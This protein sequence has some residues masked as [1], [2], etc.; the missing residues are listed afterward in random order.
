MA[1][2]HE[3]P[4]FED[5]WTHLYL[6]RGGLDKDKEGLVFRQGEGRTLIPIDQL[7]LVMLGPG[8]SITQQAAKALA[9]NNCL[10]CFVGEEGV[11]MYAFATGG[12]HSA[13]R[14]LRQ[15]EL[16]ASPAEREHVARRM[17]LKR[18]PSPVAT[19]VT[20]Q[21]LRGMEG[22]RVRKTYE[23]MALDH[24][25]KWE[26]RNYDQSSWHTADPLNR[27]LSSA[28]A[29][30]YSLCHAAILSA[31]YSPAIGFIHTGKVL[32]FVYD[33][34]DL[35][36]TEI[37]IPLAFK[38]AA[39]T[40][41][42]VERTARLACRD[43]FKKTKLIQRILPDIAEVLDARDDLGEGADELEGRAISLA[44]RAQGW[45]FP[46]KPDGQNTG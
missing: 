22:A 24:G 40:Q 30:L 38:A 27:A 32:S 31:G 15:A 16:Y 25:V 26:G 41:D 29:C 10:M 18:F 14:L 43:M 39:E 3:L 28:N 46:W 8:T 4:K 44:D 17:Y 37:T 2:L 45:G 12:T 6:E 34:A 5:R 19:D 35:Y 42:H 9:A 23:Q 21:Q 11:K 1:D 7:S 13:R 20:I 33:V 36:K